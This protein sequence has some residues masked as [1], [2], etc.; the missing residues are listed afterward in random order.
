MNS[1]TGF[2]RAMVE[3]LGHNMTVEIKTVNHRFLDF[4]IRMPRA[5]LFLED[6]VRSIIKSQLARGR[7]DVFIGYKAVGEKARKVSV[8][9]SL[10]A[11]YMA[12]SAEIAER[13]RVPNDLSMI[14]VMRL[15]DVLSFEDEPANE[16]E[17]KEILSEATKAAVVELKKARAA[18]GARMVADIASRGE[19]LE[20]ITARIKEREPVV[21]EEYK[22]K[23]A[24]RL[25]EFAKETDL[26]VNRFNAEILYFADRC[27]IAEEIVRLESHLA[28]LR[29]TL[30]SDGAAGR[31]LD[32]LVQELNREYN[33]IGSKSADVQI[34]DLVLEAKGEVEKIREQVQNIE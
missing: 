29:E 33:T 32:F 18:E 1:M 24:A 17:L 4:N 7:V 3:T 9:A 25:G 23:L 12:A 11:G 28:R 16:E 30:E 10:L 21:V 19:K 5:M 2:G 31:P 15:P 6:E 20:G 8:D 34:T 13:T 22:Q 26:D 14:D 27:A